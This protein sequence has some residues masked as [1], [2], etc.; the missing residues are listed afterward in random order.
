M[1]QLRILKVEFFFFKHGLSSSFEGISEIKFQI[2]S[3][4]YITIE[5]ASVDRVNLNVFNYDLF[6]ILFIFAI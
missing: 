6:E 2:C 1:T 5:R 4:M 3:G